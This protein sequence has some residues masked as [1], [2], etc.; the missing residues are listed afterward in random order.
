MTAREYWQRWQEIDQEVLSAYADTF[1]N[2]W[3]RYPWQQPTGAWVGVKKLPLTLSLVEQHVRGRLTIGAYAL[4][5]ASQAKW[6]CIDADEAHE[7]EKLTDLARD[8]DTQGIPSYREQSRRGGHLWLFTPLLSGTDARRF[9]GQLIADHGLDGIEIYPRRARLTEKSPV[10]SCVRLP[11]GVHQLAKHQY[12]FL[13]LNDEPLAP[14]IREQLVILAQPERVPTEFISELLKQSPPPEPVFTLNRRIAGDT[15]AER[16][17]AAVSVYD[18]VSQFIDLDRSGKG[19]C[20]FHDDHRM[21][22]SVETQGNYWH[23]FAGCKGQTVIDF[24]LKWKGYEGSVSKDVW[25]ETISELC[26]MLGI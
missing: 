5:Q 22:F 6:V 9:A 17:K 13:T 11:L 10:G 16:V 25:N 21:S 18:F 1:I 24:Y 14:T 19:L 8:L 3:D 12:Y 26:R 20:P 2:R 23:C 7:W 15:P 4:D